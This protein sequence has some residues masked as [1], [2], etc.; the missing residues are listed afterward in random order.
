MDDKEVRL[1]CIEAAAKS[2]TPHSRGYA[3][4]VQESAESWYL[5]INSQSVPEGIPAVGAEV[6]F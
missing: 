6:L 2:P 3:A 5:W 1:R 4:G